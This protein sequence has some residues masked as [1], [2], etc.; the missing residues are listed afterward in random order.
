MAMIKNRKK[1]DI[2][3]AKN[4]ANLITLLLPFCQNIDQQLTRWSNS[5]D[6]TK[7]FRVTKS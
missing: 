6:N 7:H 4:V 5:E 3:V 1:K 2:R